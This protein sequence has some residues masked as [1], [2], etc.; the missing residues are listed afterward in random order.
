[1]R[2]KTESMVRVQKEGPGFLCSVDRVD[3]IMYF[4][5]GERSYLLKEIL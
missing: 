1:M 2:D 5:T 4:W 3:R